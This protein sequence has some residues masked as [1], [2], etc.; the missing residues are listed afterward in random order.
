MDKP[1][2]FIL[3]IF[4]ASGDLTRRKVIPALFNLFCQNLLPENFALLGVARTNFS[5]LAFRE[6]ILSYIAKCKNKTIVKKRLKKFSSKIFYQPVNTVDRNDYHSIKNRLLDIS[7]CFRIKKN[8]I[9]YL[10]IVPSIYKIIIQNLGAHHLQTE[11]NGEW[12]RIVIEKPFGYDLQSAKALNL[13]LSKVFHEN[14]IYRIDHYLGKETVQNVLAFR[15]AN[16][17]F[18]PLWNHNYID[19]IEITSAEFM[20]I[21]GRGK[22]YDHIGALRDMVQN[23][24]LQ[25]VS[26]ITMEPPSSFS[27]DT[28]RGESLKVFQSLRPL[29]EEEIKKNVVRGQY[30]ES[31]IRGKKIPAYRSEKDVHDH[32]RTETYVALKFYIDNWRWHDVPFYLR[33]GKRMPTSVTEVVINF[34]QPPH[35][36]FHKMTNPNQLIIRIQPDEGILLKFGMKLPGTGF[37]IKSVDMDFHYS[38]LSGTYIPDSYERLLLDCMSGDQTL[39]IR[40]DAAEACWKFIDPII[41]C[42]KTN[43]QIKIYGYPAGSWGP[44]EANFIFE[45]S[46]SDW[47]FPCK[48]LVGNDLYCEL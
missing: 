11:D 37:Q 35:Y 34:K 45:G 4:G 17:I 27:A 22:Y 12:K 6:H 8:F 48:N 19:H 5:D 44:R 10:S 1:E 24:L 28:I 47:R 25:V 40:G 15:F 41:Q 39:Y 21:E 46:K 32:S 20:G 16:G 33:T 42:W 36:L 18:E 30:T 13:C 14:Q 38:D 26:M 31:V 7:H 9:Y 43:P 3:V 29:R 2:D 23:H